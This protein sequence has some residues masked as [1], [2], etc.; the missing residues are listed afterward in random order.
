MTRNELH[1]A[2]YQALNFFS[3]GVQFGPQDVDVLRA[4]VGVLL[5]R[6]QSFCPILPRAYLRRQFLVRHD[7]LN[8]NH[9]REAL[10]QRLNRDLVLVLLQYLQFP[11]Q[12]LQIRL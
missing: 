3:D 4:Q 6:V 10:Q 5:H 12:S 1:L 9:F 11:F 7:R 8:S 2:L